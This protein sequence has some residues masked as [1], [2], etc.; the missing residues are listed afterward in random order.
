GAEGMYICCGAHGKGAGGYSAGST[1]SRESRLEPV[2]PWELTRARNPFLTWASTRSAMAWA[3]ALGATLLRTSNSTTTYRGSVC[4]Y[5]FQ[6]KSILVTLPTRTPRKI[7]GAPTER[8]STF[9]GT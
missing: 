2:K 3:E 1:Y 6:L 8:P 7:T 5:R 9:P 4:G